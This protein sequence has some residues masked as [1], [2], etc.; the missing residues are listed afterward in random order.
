MEQ[1]LVKLDSISEKLLREAEKNTYID[2]ALYDKYSVKRGLRNANGT[3]VLVGITNVAAVEGYEIKDG[4]KIAVD[5]ELFY[6]GISV[7]EMIE[8]FQKENRF[9]FEETIFLLLFGSL[10]SRRAID[11]FEKLLQRKP[12]FSERLHPGCASQASKQ[13]H[14]E[15]AP[16]SHTFH[17]FLRRQR[18]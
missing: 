12:Q 5:G 2:P 11:A 8:N 1:K 7:G 17:V 14:N 9:G 16:K 13:K 18:G 3:G 15:Q 10:P 6:R 4:Q